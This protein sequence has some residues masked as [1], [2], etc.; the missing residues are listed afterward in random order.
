[1]IAAAHTVTGRL[2]KAERR[3]KVAS[4]SHVVLFWRRRDRRPRGEDLSC[5]LVGDRNET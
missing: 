3:F 2:E 1:M 4:F 5:D